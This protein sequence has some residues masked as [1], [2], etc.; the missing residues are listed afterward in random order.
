VISAPVLYVSHGA[1][2][3]STRSG[4]PLNVALRRASSWLSGAQAVVV[5]S[6]HDVRRTVTIGAAPRISMWHDHPAAAGLSWSAPGALHVVERL[7]AAL[8]TA[9]I[10]HEHGAAMLDHGAWVPLCAL[11]PE[12]AR[13]IVTVSLQ[14]NMDVALH[15]RLGQALGTLR[16]HGA[17]ILCS[18][19]LTHNQDEFRRRYFADAG[20]VSARV[21]PPSERFA[22][23][24]LGAM[25]MEGPARN[26][27]VM[28]APLHPDFR[29]C[30]PTLD[31]WLPTLVAVGAAGTDEGVLLHEGFQY[32]LS[33]A[34]VGFGTPTGVV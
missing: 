1:A 5:V 15:L 21:A 8:R 16:A 20:A 3:F 25:T 33:T 11:D 18:G 6:A 28:R 17:L 24:M 2:T 14:A 23:A 4:D 26:D 13:S 30:H 22:S 32:S 31:H 29:F 34:L 27:A 12:G 10:A 19:G 9:D 7:S